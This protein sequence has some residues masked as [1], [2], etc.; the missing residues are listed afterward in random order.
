MA[1][2]GGAD[3][4]GAGAAGLESLNVGTGVD[5]ALSD[6]DFFGF[7]GLGQPD[8]WPDFFR[9]PYCTHRPKGPL[10]GVCRGH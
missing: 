4:D 1:H 7:D 9:I 8:P 6:K 3:E 5:A 10:P 2:E